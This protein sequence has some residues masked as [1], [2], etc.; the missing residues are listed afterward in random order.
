MRSFPCSLICNTNHFIECL[1]LQMKAGKSAFADKNI[2]AM[3][4]FGQK[5]MYVAQEFA[6]RLF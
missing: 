2:N 3:R 1:R 5:A 4:Q 6:V